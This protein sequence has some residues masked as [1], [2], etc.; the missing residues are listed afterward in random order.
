MLMEVVSSYI[1]DRILGCVGL[2]HLKARAIM[3]IKGTYWRR[4]SWV[5]LLL[6]G[7]QAFAQGPTQVIVGGVSAIN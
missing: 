6:P 7:D 4:A 1:M 2:L 3:G 5:L